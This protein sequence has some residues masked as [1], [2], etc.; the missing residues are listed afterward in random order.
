MCCSFRNQMWSS[1]KLR[2]WSVGLPSQ[3]CWAPGW[4]PSSAQNSLAPKG[5]WIPF[6]AKVHIPANLA[7]T[8]LPIWWKPGPFEVIGVPNKKYCFQPFQL[9]CTGGWNNINPG[10]LIATSVMGQNLSKS[11]ICC[12]MGLRN[13]SQNHL[14]SSKN[15]LKSCNI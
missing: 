14:I 4:S 7:V 10:W 9:R 13:P 12:N 11:W 8:N 2:P 1:S 5:P 15:Y 6:L 3:H